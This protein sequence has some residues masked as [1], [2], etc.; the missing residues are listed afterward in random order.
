MKTNHS[1]QI[2]LNRVSPRYYRPE[3][4]IE[5][6]VLTRLEKIPTNTYESIEEGTEQIANEI[7]AKIQDRQREG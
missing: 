2:S 3:N 4:A 6:S 5:R 1:S 7:V